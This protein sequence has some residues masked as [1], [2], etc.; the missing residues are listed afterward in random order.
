M[1]LDPIN[2]GVLHNSY[3]SFSKPDDTKMFGKVN[4]QQEAESMQKDIDKL[5]QW[6][7]EWQMLFNI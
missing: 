7:V 6:S 3:I 5:V 2:L 1:W 4:N